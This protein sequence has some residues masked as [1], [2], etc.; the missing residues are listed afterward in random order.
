MSENNKAQDEVANEIKCKQ[1][2]TILFSDGQAEKL[3][4]THFA[5]SH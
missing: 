1:L 4:N 5:I 3:T 2:I